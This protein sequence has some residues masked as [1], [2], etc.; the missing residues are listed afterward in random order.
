M[1]WIGA[2]LLLALGGDASAEARPPNPESYLAS[3]EPSEVELG[4]PF[5]LRIEVRHHEGERYRLPKDLSL[6]PAVV[7]GVE[8]RSASKEGVL[9]TIFLVE[10]A[11]Y[12]ALGEVELP[13]LRLEAEDGKGA[14]AP[15]ELPGPS[16]TIR[17]IGEGV[18]LAP[19]P[20]PLSLRILAWKRLALAAGGL[21]LLAAL[22]VLLRRRRAA[23]L[24]E[25]GP[26]PT[27]V[28]QARRALGALRSEALWERGAGKVHYFRLSEIL[29]VYLRDAHGVAAVEMTT[30]ELVRAL[31]RDPLPGLAAERV[32]A[33]IRRGD[34]ARF[35]KG[36]V[37]AE[38]A[39]DD[40]EEA[41]AMIEDMEA[42]RQ[43]IAGGNEA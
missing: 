38:Q 8:E 21:A 25:T 1:I 13:A 4:R 40:L 29:R 19:P 26:G 30:E 10:A 14:L 39:L 43:P 35:A 11:V 9:E 23:R 37:A 16:L 42:A 6:E 17:E 31:R 22:I 36:E 27:P 33:W 12:S 18:E 24:Q 5:V 3:V 2:L 34:L 15:L 32:E 41:A 7:L 28:E 20:A